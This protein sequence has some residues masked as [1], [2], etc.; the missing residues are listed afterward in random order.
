MKRYLLDT[1]LLTAYLY[2]RQPAIA[3]LSPWIHNDEAATSILVYGEVIAHI[4]GSPTFAHQRQQLKDILA[5]IT[6]HFLT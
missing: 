3:L 6:P 2:N 4:K 5:A 1:T